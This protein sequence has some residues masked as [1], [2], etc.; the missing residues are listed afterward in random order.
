[1][2][3]KRTLVGVVARLP[4]EAGGTLVNGALVSIVAKMVT[5]M[6]GLMVTGMGGRKRNLRVASGPPGFEPLK[7]SLFFGCERGG[8]GG[9]IRGGRG[10]SGKGSDE[11]GRRAGGVSM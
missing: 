11:G 2:A 7:D 3:T 1:M 6:T 4:T 10:L 8:G 5:R 9:D